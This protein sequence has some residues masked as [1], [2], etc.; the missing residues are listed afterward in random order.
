M[1]RST[2]PHRRARP[3]AHRRPDGHCGPPDH[4]VDLALSILEYGRPY[5]LASGDLGF[6]WGRA[7]V[8]LTRLGHLYVLMP[9]GIHT[10]WDSRPGTPARIRRLAF[11]LVTR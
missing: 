2:T 6:R 8:C 5:Q 4:L 1:H 9:S 10:I 3:P 7:H 11:T